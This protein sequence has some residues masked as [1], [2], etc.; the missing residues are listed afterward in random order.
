MDWVVTQVTTEVALPFL[1]GLLGVCYVSTD[2]QM[3]SKVNEDEFFSYA[4]QQN[5]P[6]VNVREWLENV[7]KRYFKSS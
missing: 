5:I 4:E 1:M 7:C 3:N 2:G 6:G